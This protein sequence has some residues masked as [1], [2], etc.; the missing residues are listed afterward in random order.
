[1]RVRIPSGLPVIF[2]VD[3]QFGSNTMVVVWWYN[4]IFKQ[5]ELS[6]KGNDDLDKVGDNWI[7]M[8]TKN[9]PIIASWS[10]SAHTLISLDLTKANVVQEGMVEF[11][12]LPYEKHEL[13]KMLA[14][15]PNYQF[16]S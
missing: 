2:S 3:P 7:M 15:N 9:G 1:M 11:E 12:I 8:Q 14:E 13:L 5:Y 16:C 10:A 6:Y 4:P